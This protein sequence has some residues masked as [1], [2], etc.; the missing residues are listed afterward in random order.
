MRALETAS[1]VESRVAML[2]FF[3]CRCLLCA[4]SFNDSSYTGLPS[5]VNDPLVHGSIRKTTDSCLDRASVYVA[6]GVVAL[7]TLFGLPAAI[8]LDP[9]HFLSRRRFR[10]IVLLPIALPA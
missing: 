2:A 8:A 5:R 4:F 3:T 9:I 10:R 1:C 6:L 7:S